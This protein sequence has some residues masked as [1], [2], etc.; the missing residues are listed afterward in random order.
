MALAGCVFDTPIRVISS[1]R[2]RARAAALAIL[3]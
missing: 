3:S 1:V 2:R